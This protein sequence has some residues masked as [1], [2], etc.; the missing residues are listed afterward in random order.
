MVKSFTLKGFSFLFLF[1]TFL[2]FS[3]KARAE[4]TKQLA[5]A[6]T[7]TVQLYSN[8]SNYYNFARYGSSDNERLYIHIADPENEQ[9]FFGFSQ[10]RNSITTTSSYLDSY[11][12]VMKPDGTIARPAELIS[13]ATANLDSWTLCQEGPDA[14]ASAGGYSPWTFDPSGMPAGDYYIEFNRNQDSYSSGAMAFDYF[15]ITVATT[16]ANPSAIDGRVFAKN[17]GFAAP[18]ET[19]THPVYGSYSRPFNGA[20]FVL[21]Q[22]GYVSKIDFANA[23]FQPWAFNISLNKKGTS[24]ENSPMINRGSVLNEKANNPQ[25]PIY[26]ND[27]DATVYPSGTYG[28]LL[29]DSTEISGCSLI[30]YTIKTVTTNTGVIDF[31]LDQDQTSGVGIYDPGTA[32]RLISFYVDQQATDTVPGMYTRYVPWDGLDGLGNTV[33]QASINVNVIFSQGGNHIPIYDAEYLLNGFST[34]IVRPAPPVS[35]VLKHYYDDL[36]IPTGVQNFVGCAPGCHTWNDFNFGNK[37]TI[38]TWWFAN[39][40]FQIEA[41]PIV[42]DCGPDT[43]GDGVVDA[44][45]KDWDN[46]GIPN[47]L[48]ACVS[49]YQQSLDIEILLDEN[50]AET[51]WSLVDMNGTTVMSGSGYSIQEELI[52]VTYTGDLEGLT[53]TIND[54]GAD[55]ILDGYYKLTAGIHTYGTT[56]NG[57]FGTNASL[58]TDELISMQCLNGL[59]PTKDNDNDGIIDYKDI[60]YC[61]L[62]SFGICEALDLDNDGIPS[63]LDLDGDNDGIPDIVESGNI[64]E[65]NDGM[66]DFATTGDPLTMVD[67]DMDGLADI[68][69]LNDGGTYFYPDTD[70]DGKVD[71]FDLDA[72]GDGLSDLVEVNGVDSNGNGIVDE[73]DAGGTPDADNNGWADVYAINPLVDESLLDPNINTDGDAVPNHLDI[74]SDNDGITDVIESG[75]MDGNMDGMADD[76]T[77]SGTV[78]D[79]NG[80]GWDDSHDDG[81]TATIADGSGDVNTFPDFVSGSGNDDFDGDGIP[82]WLDID[83]DNDGIID[84]IEGVCSVNCVD[85]SGTLVD[86]NGNGLWD[87]YEGLLDSNEPGGTNVGVNPNMDDDDLVDSDPDFL[88]LNAD[89]DAAFD[90]IEGYDADMDGNA[91]DDLLEYAT[92]YNANSGAVPA[93][94]NNALDSDNDGIPNWM[95]N[96]AGPGYTA[97]QHPPFLDPSNNQYWI[98]IDGNGLADIFD[99]AQGGTAAPTPN[100]NGGDMDW[101]DTS[102]ETSL[103]L[104]LV[105]FEVKNDDCINRISW[106]TE[107]EYAVEELI[108]ERSLNG[109]DFISIATFSA[110]GSDRNIYEFNDEHV[111]QKLYYRLRIVELSRQESYSK[112]VGVNSDCFESSVAIYPNPVGL[113]TDLNI[114]LNGVTGNVEIKVLDNIGRLIYTDQLIT[115][116]DE[117][118]ILL[119]TKALTVGLF[120]LQIT[121]GFKSVSTSFIVK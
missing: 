76:G 46:D 115:R 7:D 4:G 64:D 8:S 111:E 51:S 44:I 100:A 69:D 18:P 86:A 96:L 47:I 45:D 30:G 102:T 65:N 78:V 39:Q 48:E 117:N 106:I 60:D 73:I 23:G 59:D 62:N 16:G 119:P 19:P 70:G 38:N 87:V 9:V 93:P 2:I 103:P 107:Q 10:A 89:E 75:N 82:N 68:A 53:F 110:K 116:S 118:F 54:T 113:S 114:E 27:P 66:V 61:T 21:T 63:F 24:L 57:S 14:I 101:R 12:R 35:Y 33:S 55:G 99:P 98:D 80:D 81:I 71:L 36:E 50:P 34:E 97:A 104:S 92:D 58:V 83:A 3:D 29:Q 40:E 77:A 20:F 11:F 37:N 74:D 84:E 95:D 41:M 109:V 121:N 26:I 105:F 17:W 1:F 15:D 6:Q 72:D 112:V 91:I 49:P 32:D 42:E 56:Y 52:M 28:Q 94:F 31:L 13:A 43:D 67:T 90:W 5:P 108:L 85:Q 79:T 22:E 120:H 25:Y 88:D